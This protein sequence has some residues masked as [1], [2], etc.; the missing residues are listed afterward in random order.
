MWVED[1]ELADFNGMCES[2]H[3]R[4]EAIDEAISS[5][6]YDMRVIENYG[7]DAMAICEEIIKE[8]RNE[9]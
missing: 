5:I 4:N 2:C 9:K 3:D 6:R 7:Y 1:N 8:I